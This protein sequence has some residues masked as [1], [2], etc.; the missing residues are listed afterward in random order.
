[1]SQYMSIVVCWVYVKL[2]DKR[3]VALHIDIKDFFPVF[4]P[5]CLRGRPSFRLVWVHI[6]MC[7]NN[8]RILKKIPYIK[9]MLD[10]LWVAHK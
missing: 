6:W 8:I 7:L 2:L 3:S 9:C 1:M 4:D 10:N 5:V